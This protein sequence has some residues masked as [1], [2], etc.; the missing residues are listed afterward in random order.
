MAN[1][2]IRRAHALG[3]EKAK[4]AVDAVALQLQA[5]LKARSQWQ[6]D[7]LKF[8][9]PGAHGRIDVT[10]DALCVS[11]ELSWLL[12]AARGRITQSIEEYLD[13]YVA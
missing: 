13:R 11:V 8:D 5:D 6:G 10:H 1:I 3:M 2:E 7:A 9:C 12:S 4:A